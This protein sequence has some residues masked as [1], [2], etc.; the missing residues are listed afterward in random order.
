M[1]G[2]TASKILKKLKEQQKEEG[3]LPL[4]LEFYQKLVQVQSRAQKRIGTPGIGLSS[5]V[6]QMRLT[7]GQSLLG[8]DELSLDWPLVRKVFAETAAAF[9]GYPQ[10][11]GE[12]PDGLEGPEVGKRLDESAVRAWFTGGELSDTLIE[13]VSKTLV[14]TILQATMQPFLAS[15]ALALR[16]AVKKESLE[17]WRRG[18]CP[19]CGGSP[20][21]AYLEK[22]VGARWLVCSRCDFEWI[23]QRLECPYCR[24]NDQSTLSFFSDEEGLYRLYVCEKCRC[25]LKA[26][27]LRKAGSEV[28]LP[29]ERLYTLDLDTQARERG[30]HPCHP[31]RKD[32]ADGR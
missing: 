4:L 8:F 1:T 9:A 23:F 16:D 32:V 27:D 5:E 15:H 24:N 25:Y 21:L 7:R 19:V 31:S 11:F 22:E 3:S 20:D 12:L 17:A 2:D 29:L 26:I 18:Y 13:G 28:L 6:I 30:Y 14:E 10:L